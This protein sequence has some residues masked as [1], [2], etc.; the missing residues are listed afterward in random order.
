MRGGATGRWEGCGGTRHGSRPT[1]PAPMAPLLGLGHGKPATTGPQIF[2]GREW[3][4]VTTCGLS[5]ATHGSWHV[6]G[7]QSPWIARS[8]SG[9][10]Q[11]R[12]PEE[13]TDPEASRPQ[14]PGVCGQEPETDCSLVPH[15]LAA[16]DEPHSRAPA[17]RKSAGALLAAQGLIECRAVRTSGRDRPEAACPAGAA[18]TARRAAGAPLRK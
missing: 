4:T 1:A 5:H 13:G 12:R 17:L 8:P 7:P 2:A 14:L 10:P 11:G 18:G 3:I 9:A 16:E 15:G 6:P